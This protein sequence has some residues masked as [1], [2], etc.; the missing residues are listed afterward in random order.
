MMAGQSAPPDCTCIIQQHHDGRAVCTSGLQ[1]VPGSKHQ[2]HRAR[3]SGLQHSRLCLNKSGNITAGRHG[4]HIAVV[5][6]TSAAAAWLHGLS[7]D[8]TLCLHHQT[9]H[10]LQ[11]RTARYVR[12]TKQ[13]T[14]CRS[15][16]HAMSCLLYT[17]PSPRD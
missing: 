6:Q 2:Q 5:V 16:L 14:I 7:Q 10:N 1:S 17:S 9:T 3:Q 11:V 8:C 12:I 4:L 15:G 13:H